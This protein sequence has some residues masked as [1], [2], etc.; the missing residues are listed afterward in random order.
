MQPS[1]ELIQTYQELIGAYGKNCPPALVPKAKVTSF[2]VEVA[3]RYW[4]RE[5]VTETQ[6]LGSYSIVPQECFT[7]QET[8]RALSELQDMTYDAVQVMDENDPG[9]PS[10]CGSYPWAEYAVEKTVEINHGDLSIVVD[11]PECQPREGVQ[12]KY[13]TSPFAVSKIVTDV[14]VAMSYGCGADEGAAGGVQVDAL[15]PSYES[16][17]VQA[18]PPFN[19]CT[20]QEMCEVDDVVDIVVHKMNSEFHQFSLPLINLQFFLDQLRKN[21]LHVSVGIRGTRMFH[22]IRSRWRDANFFLVFRIDCNASYYLSHEVCTES[23]SYYVVG[24]YTTGWSTDDYAWH[25]LIQELPYP[26]LTPLLFHRMDHRIQVYPWKDQKAK[27]FINLQQAMGVPIAFLSIKGHEMG[28]KADLTDWCFAINNY[29]YVKEGKTA[30]SLHEELMRWKNVLIVV[31]GGGK[32]IAVTRKYACFPQIETWGAFCAGFVDCC[33]PNPPCETACAEVVSS[34]RWCDISP[35]SLVVGLKKRFLIPVYETKMSS[36]MVEYG[37]WEW[38]SRWR[39][40]PCPKHSF[41]VWN[42]NF[43]SPAKNIS[44]RKIRK[45]RLR[46][47]KKKQE[48]SNYMET[49]MEDSV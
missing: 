13:S 29:K 24:Y 30:A 36:K 26:E 25:D 27:K 47:L 8:L 10:A 46:K 12:H 1:A 49:E 16:G 41:K 45:L 42:A 4:A 14:S 43:K 5:Y 34:M 2:V 18:L 44:G 39:H 20:Q 38:E 15:V 33:N 19:F 31:R 40:D 21:C 37:G 7:D 11:A 48:E 22:K 6:E 3:G 28:E 35:H 32:E 9:I 23:S 17:V